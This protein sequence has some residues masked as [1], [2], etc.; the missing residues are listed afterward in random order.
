VWFGIFAFLNLVIFGILTIA[1]PYLL[2]EGTLG[3]PVVKSKITESCLNSNIYAKENYKLFKEQKARTDAV[4]DVCLDRLNEGCGSQYY[5]QQPQIS[6]K[7]SDCPFPGDICHHGTEALEITH[8][9]FTTFE[10]GINSRP[11]LALNHRLT[12]APV[13]LDSFLKFDSKEFGAGKTVISVTDG[14]VQGKTNTN[15]GNYMEPLYTM[16]GPNSFSNESSGKRAFDVP[17]KEN[18][19][20]NLKVLPSYGYQKGERVTSFIHPGLRRKDGES[21]LIIQR[22]GRSRSVTKIDDPFFAAHQAVDFG[23]EVLTFPI[24]YIP[25]YE[26]TALGCFEQFQFCDPDLDICTGWGGSL[27]N[28]LK[29]VETQ[30]EKKGI[31]S[32]LEYCKSCIISIVLVPELKVNLRPPFV[33]LK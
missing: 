10:L 13:Q 27:D 4:I 29:D 12:C 3:A 21:F 25:D 33:Q 6:K 26:A 15:E 5:L 19:E 20:F 1:L 24:R 31:D 22:A 17:I 2:L 16:N 11:K 8:S 32:G 18:G 9:N 30:L 23:N 28:S 14:K 7:R